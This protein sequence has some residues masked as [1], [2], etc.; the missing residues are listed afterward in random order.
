MPLRH[1]YQRLRKVGWR[2]LV[3]MVEDV[4][5]G[6]QS[7][8]S[9]SHAMACDCEQGSGL[10]RQFEVPCE[11]NSQV[12]TSSASLQLKTDIGACATTPAKKNLCVGDIARGILERNSRATIRNV[13][14]VGTNGSMPLKRMEIHFEG[15]E[16][17]PAFFNSLAAALKRSGAQFHAVWNSGIPASEIWLTSPVNDG[18][19]TLLSCAGLIGEQELLSRPNLHK[20]EPFHK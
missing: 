5:E 1:I 4:P 17:V 11:V 6:N 13:L 20:A 12:A 8:E 9:G 19:K 7:I 15:P 18:K 3:Q 10:E 14:V 2:L 16:Q